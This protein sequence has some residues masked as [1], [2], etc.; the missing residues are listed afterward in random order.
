VKSVFLLQSL[1]VSNTSHE[2]NTVFQKRKRILS[3]LSFPYMVQN[4]M[5]SDA[6]YI[7][8]VE[9]C[10]QQKERQGILK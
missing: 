8:T 9:F 5:S 6:F 1:T 3:L 2:F 4:N 7:V 10:A